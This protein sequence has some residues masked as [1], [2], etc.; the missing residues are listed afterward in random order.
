MGGFNH[1]STVLATTASN[2]A[3]SCSHK[4]FDCT[5]FWPKQTLIESAY[6]VFMFI[7]ISRDRKLVIG[8]ALQKF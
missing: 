1:Q 6:L 8:T 4:L 5:C 7:V 2:Q 3:S